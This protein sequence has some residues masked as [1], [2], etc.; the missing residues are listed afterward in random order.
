MDKIIQKL[1]LQ[2]QTKEE[3]RDLIWAEM[4]K[5]GN[6]C[7][8]NYIDT[9]LITDFNCLFQHS[10]FN[11]NISGWNVSGVTDMD[12]MFLKSKFN[13]DISKWDV[14]NVL[15]MREMF[16]GSKFNQDIS[17]WSISLNSRREHMF[18]RSALSEL[19]GVENPSFE[20]VKSHYLNLKLEAELQTAS[21][22]QSNVFKVRL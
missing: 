14:S 22:R 13:G 3:L 21:P 18:L 8:L 17:A 20:Q 5:K 15:D 12:G 11:G 19:L 2:P 16:Y 9:S 1:T 7:D 4:K 10:K 6:R